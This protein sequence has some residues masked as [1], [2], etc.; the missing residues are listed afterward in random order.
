[1][2]VIGFP[3]ESLGDRR[4]LLTP[5]LAHHLV[6]AGFSPVA[7]SS[8]GAG[9]GLP[10]AE[11]R[12]AGVAL[13]ARETVWDSPLILRY[14]GGDVTELAGLRP[15]QAL[16]A[17]L[18]AEGDPALMAALVHNQTRA[19]AFEFIEDE[20]R[21]P[22]GA[23][24]GEIAGVQAVLQAAQALQSPRGRGVLL[25]RVAGA[26]PAHVVIL[27]SGHAGAAAARTAAA[28]GARVTVLT[29]ERSLAAY[30]QVAPAGVAVWPNTP[31]TLR[32][33]LPSADVLIGTL[34]VS[35]VDTP[36]M[37]GEQDLD[38]MPD[39]AAIID[40]TCGYGSGYLPTAGPVQAPGDP[41]RFVRGV[42]HIK[43]D[44]L[45]AMVPR[46]ASA[47]YARHMAPY[48]LRLARHALHGVRDEGIQRALVAAHGRLIHPVCREHAAHWRAAAEHTDAEQVSA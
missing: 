29:T 19:Y 6:A 1:M 18:H 31:A 5:E 10:D 13:A 12:E 17:L 23:P 37:L 41:P 3:R 48:L 32:E 14:R 45:P 8:L 7:E 34:L 47:A 35:T 42:A 20:G 4:T 38:L 27:G 11:L 21:F 46:T 16:G 2:S 22:T 44:C 25:A 26:S 40:V 30:R 15:D 43:V 24:G 33:L 28:L 9:I 36:A 39:G